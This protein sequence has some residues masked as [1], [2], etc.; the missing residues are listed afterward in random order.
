MHLDSTYEKLAASPIFLAKDELTERSMAEEL[1]RYF[2]VTPPWTEG[3]SAMHEA[4]PE[5]GW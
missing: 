5:Y 2:G 3:E 1:Y 4:A